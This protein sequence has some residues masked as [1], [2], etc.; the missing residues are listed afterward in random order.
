VSSGGRR[1]CPARLVTAALNRC[2]GRPVL[3]GRSPQR[4]RGARCRSAGPLR[5]VRPG[6]ARP[7][8]RGGGG[9]KVGFS[10]RKTR[11][12]EINKPGRT[13][14]R[15]LLEGWAAALCLR[16]RSSAAP[17]LCVGSITI[18]SPS[19]GRVPVQRTELRVGRPDHTSETRG[20]IALR[21]TLPVANLQQHNS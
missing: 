15:P 18:E 6:T 8:L 2:D 12:V 16:A 17:F 19:S 4:S 11:C 5:T 9:A 7:E 10:G 3:L 1:D 13:S 21:A 20:N 14:G